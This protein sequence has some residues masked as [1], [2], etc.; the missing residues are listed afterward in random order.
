MRHVALA[1]LEGAGEESILDARRPIRAP[2]TTRV[3]DA[4]IGALARVR[5]LDA[6]RRPLFWT[7]SHALQWGGFED[8]VL[9]RSCLE[10]VPHHRQF[11]AAW[12]QR[13]LTS[14]DRAQS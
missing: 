2:L 8:E 7:A 14:A 12:E 1:A 10:N 11:I 9:R 13:N 6:I 3:R 5:Y 4:A